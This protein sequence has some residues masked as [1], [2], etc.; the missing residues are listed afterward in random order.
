VKT[1]G[2]GNDFDAAAAMAAIKGKTPAG[3][4]LDA[5]YSQNSGTRTIVPK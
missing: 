2:L 4:K 1:L 3:G 5:V